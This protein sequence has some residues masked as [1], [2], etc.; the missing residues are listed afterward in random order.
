[1]YFFLF[2][3]LRPE[4]ISDLVEDIIAGIPNA[5]SGSESERETT[6]CAGIVI[7]SFDI[8]GNAT[9]KNPDKR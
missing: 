3:P 1:L 4:K 7:P 6:R 8:R 5:E 9:E 2:L